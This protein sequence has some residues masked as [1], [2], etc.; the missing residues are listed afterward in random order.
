M[1]DD[2]NKPN[3]FE[4]LF[5]KTKENLEKPKTPARPPA[6]PA[7]PRPTTPA[8]ARPPAPPQAQPGQDK[9]IK[10]PLTGGK[11]DT[12]RQCPKKFQLSYLEKR[13]SGKAVSPHLSFDTSLHTALKVFFKNR[14]KGELPRLDALMA[15]L[16]G[17]WDN[18]GYVTSDEELEWRRNAEAA[19]RL[20]FSKIE[21]AFPNTHEVDMFFKVD[22]FG[23]EYSGKFDRVDILPDGTYGIVDY[24]TGK[25]PLGGQ[26]E[27]EA[28]VTL[29]LLFHV[30]D[31]IWPGKVQTITHHFLRDGSSLTVR[32]SDDRMALAKKAYLDVGEGIYQSRF[33]P[34]RSSACPWCEHQEICPVGR[35]P[36]LTASKVRA[37]LDCPHKYA[38]I[39]VTR[40]A[41]KADEAPSVDLAFDRSLHDALTA[42]H[43]DYRPGHETEPAAFALNAFY[44]AIPSVFAEDSV[45]SMKE[46]GREMLIRYC[47]QDYVASHTRMINEFLSVLTDRYEYQATIDRIDGDAAGNLELI[48]YKTGKRVLDESDMRQDPIIAITCAAAARRWPG[49]AKKFSLLYLRTGRRV[50]IDIDEAVVAR[51]NSLIDEIADRI[52]NRQFEALGGPSCASCRASGTCHGERISISMAKLQTMRECPKRFKFRYID[53]A[54]VPERERPALTFSQLLRETLREFCLSGK[55]AALA[56]LEAMFDT[57]L[58]SS[59]NLSAA[60]RI[61]LRDQ[62]RKALAAFHASCGGT[63][64]RSKHIGFQARANIDGFLL[65]AN[66]DRVDVLPNGTYNIIIYKTGKRAPTAHETATDISGILAWAVADGNWPGKIAQVTHQYLMTGDTVAFTASDRDLEKLK[67]AIGEFHEAASSE[68]FEGNRNP[69]CPS[70]DYVESCEDAKRLLLSPSKI[71]SFTSCG[72]KYRMNYIDRVPREPRPTPHLSFDR[73]VHYALREYH[74][75]SLGAKPSTSPFRGLIAKYWTGEGFTDWDEEQMFRARAVLMLDAYFEALTGAENPV[76]FE[77]SARWTLDGMDL[78]VQIDRIDELP[79][80][81]FEIIDYKTGKKMLDERVLADDMGVMN[82]FMAANQRWPGRVA[83]ASYHYMAVNKRVSIS[84]TEAEIAA[85]TARVRALADEIGKGVFEPKKGALCNYCEFYGPCP[86]WKVKP[87]VVAGETPEV[88]R[89]RIRLSYSKMGLYENCP[90]AYGRLYIQR[91]PPKPQPFFSFGT[92]IHETFENI[93]DP[94][95]PIEKPSLEEVLRIFEEVRMTHREGYGTA[96]AEEK[97]R[98][99]GI[100]QLKMYYERFIRNCEFRPAHSI[101]DYFEIPCGKY[102]VMTGFIDRIDRLPDGTYEILDYKTEPTMRSQEE[103]DKDKQLSIYYWACE[104]TMNLRISKLSLFMLDHDAKIETTRTRDSIKKVVEHVDEIAWRMI[105]EKEFKPK[106]NKYCKSCDHLHDCPL[107]DEIMADQNLISMKKF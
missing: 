92:T 74:E 50:T 28:N 53:K 19:L 44:K 32:R 16:D 98:Q 103:V 54:P 83:K 8:V 34:V 65:T 63:P 72:L 107:K 21:V 10:I 31:I 85:H 80:G 42:L 84:P 17:S 2:K 20:F 69:L 78:V 64:P 36:A 18:R 90:R 26:A 49:K 27:L 73:T 39:Y 75:T 67:L 87:Y 86:E 7:A 91:I 3:L 68:S 15:A 51:G 25:P 52:R 102:A 48:D 57:R 88:F 61:Q 24:K 43:R 22:L 94:A 60:A 47:A 76:M 95:H 41:A 62:S 38:S 104:D 40:T 99:D 59:E 5:R 35:I 56:D 45:L 13:S 4:R 37:F 81:K 6:S 101:E 66:F 71:N 14:R 96:E 93:Y 106:K 12:Y 79:D 100:R 46:A 89:K 58:A 105:N 29:N 97:Y 23:S 30:A 1:P 11:V 9:K 82:L 70:C 33:E 77:T 55:P